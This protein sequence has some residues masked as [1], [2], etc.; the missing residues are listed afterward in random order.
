[1]YVLIPTSFIRL[2]LPAYNR[3]SPFYTLTNTSKEVNGLGING[4]D[5]FLYGIEY[6]RT[7]I[8]ATCSFSNLH[9]MRYDAAGTK[10]DLGILPAPVGGAVNSSMG[11]VS[12][13]GNFVYSVIDGSGNR[14]IA[15]VNNIAALAASAGTLSATFK[16][17]T[18]NCVI[19]AYADWSVN[20]L[21]NKLYTYGIYNNGGV[22][23]GTVVEID[24]AAGTVSCVGNPNTTEFLDPVRD[25]FGGVYFAP[26]GDLFGVNINTRRLYRIDVTNGNI[27][28]VST[29]TGAGQI[30]ADMGSCTNGSLLLPLRFTST[31]I[32]TSD[33]G[34]YLSW[35][36]AEVENLSHFIIEESDN[37]DFFATESVS[38][39]PYKTKY[40]LTIPSSSATQ[41][42][43]KA[44]LKGGTFMYSP[45]LITRQKSETSIKLV[46]SVVND[47]VE[48]MIPTKYCTINIPGREYNRGSNEKRA[49]RKYDE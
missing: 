20:P 24:P 43:I 5:G 1:M 29:M 25:N 34:V 16:Q 15:A 17:L 37:K 42:R 9:L 45:F 26:S 18:N 22:S 33:N 30:R 8:G 40:N 23:T 27:V 36:M 21:N 41:Y 39:Q 14:Y 10:A 11:C 19:A 4:V 13:E 48:V 7:A 32:K 46:N 12:R 38:A 35:E 3:S 6:D 2:A 28:H 31:S 49:A 44:V 47:M